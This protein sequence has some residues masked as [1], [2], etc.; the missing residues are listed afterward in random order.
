MMNASKRTIDVILGISG[1]LLV[2]AFLIGRWCMREGKT[3][4]EGRGV[5]QRIV[6]VERSD[7]TSEQDENES[8]LSRILK[9]TMAAE[10]GR[11]ELSVEAGRVV[12]R[13]SNGMEEH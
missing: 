3:G 13:K 6:Q 9:Y 1:C 8:R 4:I 12:G 5:V 7:Q 10:A 11:Y 2:A